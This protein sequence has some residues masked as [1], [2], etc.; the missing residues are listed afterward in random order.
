MLTDL[1]LCASQV[2]LCALP[3]IF[4]VS[5]PQSAVPLS[6][7]FPLS[8]AA[9]NSAVASKM[10]FRSFLPRDCDWRTPGAMNLD[11]DHR[12]SHFP[13]RK[14]EFVDTDA[15]ALGLGGLDITFDAE[16]SPNGKIRVR[17]HNPASALPSPTSS[18]ST[19]FSPSPPAFSFDDIPSWSVASSPVS[20]VSP[21]G[22]LLPAAHIDTDPFVGIGMS[23]ADLGFSFDPA[24]LFN[25]VPMQSEVDTSRGRR[26]VRIA[27]KSPPTIDGSA[28]EW[29]V[30]L[31]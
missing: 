22:P 16:P 8:N 18:S 11:S 25:G 17:I 4:S 9:V 6:G 24:M 26:R 1:L 30:E 13:R 14:L 2:L 10:D 19:P 29:E 15:R 20:S 3:S 12:V 23:N 28:G 5:T 21:S 27:L 7:T 31:C